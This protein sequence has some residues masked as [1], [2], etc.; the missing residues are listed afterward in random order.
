MSPGGDPNKEGAAVGGALAS[1]VAGAD[2]DA[3]ADAEFN[4][5]CW[6]LLSEVRFSPTNFGNITSCWYWIQSFLA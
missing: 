1:C 5:S 4:K 6:G 3:D 2:A